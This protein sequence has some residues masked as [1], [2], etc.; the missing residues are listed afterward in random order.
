MRRL[1]GPKDTLAGAAARALG[2]S[3]FSTA[4]TR[5]GLMGFGVL[6]ARVLG[7]REFGTSAVAM[8]AL[9][10]ILSFNELGVSLAIVRWPDDPARIAPTVQTIAAVSS[11]LL[12]AGSFFGA[13]AFAAAMG[14]PA[15]SGVIRVLALSIVT[16]GLVAVPAALLQRN[17][18]QGRKM[19]ADQ[20]HGMLG[21]VVSAGLALSGMGAMSIAIGQVAGAVA[22][23]V[24]ITCF[25]PLPPRFGFD[26]AAARRLLGFGVPLAGSSLIVFLVGNVDNFIVGHLLGAT[27]LGFYVL[28]WNL[29]SWPVNMFSQPVRAVAP[30]FFARLQRDPP[31]MRRGFT[32]AAQLLAAVTLPVCLVMSG[33][34][35]PLVRL[36][37]GAQWATAAQALA[38]LAMLAALRILFELSYDYFVV[39][40]RS[41]VVFTVQLGWLVALIPGLAFSARL[42]GLRGVALAGFAVAAMVVLPWYLWELR[43]VGIRVA[44][45]AVRLWQPLLAAAAAGFAALAAASMI[46]IDLLAVALAGVGGLVA[47]AVPCYRM[48]GFFAELRSSAAPS[49]EV[50]HGTAPDTPA[51]GMAGT[52]SAV[53]ADFVAVPPPPPPREVLPVYRDTVAFFHWD[54]AARPPSTHG[55]LST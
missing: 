12:Y 38:W 31:A 41:R 50:T 21:A 42:G 34:A 8:V 19:I 33:A 35:K 30:A 17:F 52:A 4:L 6:L 43:R 1:A 37:Y 15:A 16:N 26:P 49:P 46:K 14:A 36:V 7:P 28:A 22:G 23:G 48:R 47:I 39:L 40:A 3:F 29:A 13:P 55:E 20:V 27:T 53:A 9:L 51:A 44:A 25:A 2:W 18:M 5:F 11:V 54:P 10:A 24:L 45:F 32:S